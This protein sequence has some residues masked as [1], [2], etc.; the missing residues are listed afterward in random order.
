MGKAGDMNSALAA[1]GSRLREKEAALSR[2][3]ISRYIPDTATDRNLA[4]SSLGFRDSL[5][6]SMGLKSGASRACFTVCWWELPYALGL[7]VLKEMFL[8]V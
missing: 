7:R 1:V 5:Y 8:F 2:N 3:G 6:G 4:T